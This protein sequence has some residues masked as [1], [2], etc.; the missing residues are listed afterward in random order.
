MENL[1]KYI[2]SPNISVKEAIAQ[3]ETTGKKTVIVVDSAKKIVGIFTDGDMR[4][5]V[6]KN[7]DLSAPVSNAMN[8]NPIVFRKN[9]QEEL[10]KQIEQRCHLVYPIV[11]DENRLVDIVYWN[12]NNNKIHPNQ[13]LPKEVQVVIMAGGEGTR[14]YPYTK[15]LPKPLIPIEDIP[16]CTHVI[17]SFKKY[18]CID[19][20]LILNHKSN[21]IKAYYNDIEKDFNLNYEVED[22][23][24]GTA[25][26][27]CLLKG[28]IKD[29]CFIS[30]CDILVNADYSC[31]YKWHKKEK[32]LIT[33]ICALKE[34]QIP[35]GV[36]NSTPNGEI[37]NI[38][39]K[40]AFSFL[41]NVGVYLIEPEVI[42]GLNGEFIHMP[43]LAQDYINKGKKVGV[44][45]I[46]PNDWLDMGQIKEMEN[47]TKQLKGK[48]IKD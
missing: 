14:L 46:A 44:F 21:M 7:G 28:E 6:L 34:V 25:G 45:P 35:Y 30:N 47:M 27:L 31:I 19:Y 26:G 43:N 2:I 24:L 32:N 15:V 17:N 18:G 1:E 16:I 36:I 23:F 29:T 37:K 40:P 38:E 9:Q 42:D 20:T 10:E 48:W 22:K 39:E 13:I 8:K 5:Y 12:D 41:I 3:I 4:R 11:D 33:M